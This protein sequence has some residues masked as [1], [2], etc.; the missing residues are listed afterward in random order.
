MCRAEKV[1][2]T[3]IESAL[4]LQML[5]KQSAANVAEHHFCMGALIGPQAHLPSL[6][7]ACKGWHSA[8]L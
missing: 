8:L 4:I 3:K 7:R 1:Q 5:G 2:M 6:A